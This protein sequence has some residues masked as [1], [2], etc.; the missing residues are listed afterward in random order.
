MKASRVVVL[1]ALL[2]LRAEAA[3]RSIS[4]S[5]IS[6]P[7]DLRE[8]RHTSFHPPGLDFVQS[9]AQTK[10]GF[11]WLATPTGLFRY[12]GVRFD[13]ELGNRL[14]SPS[15]WA[16]LADP[17][18]SLWIGYRFG[19]VSVVRGGQVFSVNGGRLPPG[20]VWQLFRSSDGTLWAATPS[21]LAR[22]RGNDWQTLGE[23]DGYSG[24]GPYWMGSKGRQFLVVTES[25]AFFYTPS[26]GRFERRPKGEGEAVRYGIP[27]SSAWRPDLHETDVSQPGQTMLDRTGSLW[28]SENNV[29]SRYRWSSPGDAAPRRDEMAVDKGLTGSMTSMLEDQEGNIWVGTT[30]GV[31]RFSVPRAH[32]VVLPA[33]LQPLLIPG[34]HGETWVS[35][36]HFPVARLKDHQKIQGLEGGATAAFRGEDGTLWLAGGPMLVQYRNGEILRRLAPPARPGNEDLEPQ[37]VAV[38][39]DGAVWLSIAHA[40]LFRW[41]GDHWSRASEHYRLPQGPAIRLAAGPHDRLWIAYPSNRLAVVDGART[42]VY[43]EAEGLNVGNVLA[44]D[45]EESHAWVAGD[46]G[47]EV[48]VGGRF[49]PVR[50]VG[51]FN[52]GS[53]SGVVE[54][55]EGDLWLNGSKGVYHI[56]AAEV[57]SVL[58]G[59]SHTVDFEVLGELDGLTGVAELLRPGPTMQ[60]SPDGRLWVAHYENAW[61]IDLPHFSRNPVAPILSIEDLVCNGVHY[62]TDG[63][64]ELPSGSRNLQID[65]TAAMLTNPERVRFRY[66]LIGVDDEWQD[67]GQR[68]QAYYTNLG[69]RPYEF[70]VMA[71]N[72]DGVW[73]QQTSV[74]RFKVKPLFY[75]TLGFKIVVAVTAMVLL[76]LIFVVRLDQIHR[77]Y[78][79]EIETRHAER[80][81]IARDLHDTLLQGVQ[82]LLFRLRMWEDDP[83]I[84]E[85]KR[86]EIT[87][88]SRQ[89]AAMVV[90]GRERILMMRRADT[91]PGDLVESLT[92]IGNE[93][94]AGKAPAFEVEVVGNPRTLGV[95]AKEQLLDIAREAI[96][97]ACKHSGAG[98]ITAT[99]EYRK[100]S[101]GLSI[102]DDGRGFDPASAPQDS[103]SKHFGLTGMRERARQLGAEFHV[104]SDSKTGTRIEVIVPGR[105]AFLDV[106]RWPWDRRRTVESAALERAKR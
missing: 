29:L 66:R 20:S 88:V 70:Q 75:Q 64:V 43:T 27:E 63:P 13:T 32:K 94:A 51:D 9:M 10:D 48:L 85:S 30:G 69:P 49:T 57:R 24:E 17:D 78:R 47:L 42:T 59:T 7:Y 8:L 52:L 33:N 34:D 86:T 38:S 22:L 54:T 39:A 3:P 1:G 60:K 72:E 104:C 62:K 102:V 84:P 2:A 95:D 11:L 65:Y 103:R 44:L 50:G 19:G 4:E 73:S 74:L 80:E 99:L 15:I 16:L 87:S 76:A 45:I 26:T 40:D 46:R 56:P 90:E 35:G 41:D 14:P 31:D 61:S 53:A 18:G 81:R 23:Q 58:A 106:F 12:D 92:M 5:A 97:N 21:G 37:A 71:A 68:R 82:A 79:R 77:R 6:S 28:L 93:A 55:S 83:A 91:Q 96:R 105:V 25:A 67:V 98:R 36:W 101:L 100:R 89:T